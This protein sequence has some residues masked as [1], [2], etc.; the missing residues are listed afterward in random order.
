M[1]QYDFLEQEKHLNKLVEECPYE[2]KLAVTKW[3]MECILDH[4]IRGGSFREL[5]YDR[6]GF[7]SD[8]Y[9]VLMAPALEIH[10]EFSIK[11]M[12]IIRSLV[13]EHKI[14]ELK[15]VLRMCGADECFH[16]AS[17]W[18]DG[19]Q[20]CS[21]HCEEYLYGAKKWNEEDKE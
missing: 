19:K 15:K 7:G 12:E 1:S 11:D 17:F 21:D 10:C 3:A 14:K 2:T 9:D 6:L 4:A 20:S 18:K 5:I 13:R 16:S 8:A